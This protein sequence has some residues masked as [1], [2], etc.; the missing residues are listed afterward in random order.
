MSPFINKV[1]G[2][3]GEGRSAVVVHAFSRD[4]N[5]QARALLQDASDEVVST[6]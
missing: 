2:A 3:I 6:L 4:Q 1:Q 5:A